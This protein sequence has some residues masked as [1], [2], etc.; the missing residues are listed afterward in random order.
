MTRR[1]WEP[2]LTRCHLRRKS[3]KESQKEKKISSIGF[4]TASLWAVDELRNGTLGVFLSLEI[5]DFGYSPVKS[6]TIP[7]RGCLEHL[8]KLQFE[9]EEHRSLVR[10]FNV[11]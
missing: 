8:A 11:P 7:T 4:R 3:Q 2:G 9:G 6:F 10:D 1:S 5:S